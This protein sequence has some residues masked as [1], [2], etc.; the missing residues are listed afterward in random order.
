MG[1]S[2]ESNM[3]TNECACLCIERRQSPGRPRRKVGKKRPIVARLSD[4]DQE[5]ITELP[6]MRRLTWMVALLVIPALS[7]C[8][9]EDDSSYVPDDA[10][11]DPADLQRILIRGFLEDG[12]LN[13]HDVYIVRFAAVTYDQEVVPF[14]GQVK[15]FLEPQ[16]DSDKDWIPRFWFQEVTPDGFNT[17]AP[18]PY[19][20]V[21]ADGE[22]LDWGEPVHLR[23][24]AL[25]PD[26]RWIYG[27]RNSH[28]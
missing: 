25:L 6:G 28:A 26:G 24:E 2:P 21:T 5:P 19:W 20:Q 12:G 15:V 23:A 18:L 4:K 17:R 10:E 7:G 27:E 13:E 16:E 1:D 22:Y 9:S 3:F 11:Q 8:T 14:E